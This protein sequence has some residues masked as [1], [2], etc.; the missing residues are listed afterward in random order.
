MPACS[1][2]LNSPRRPTH[3]PAL[4]TPSAPPSASAGT[5]RA[6]AGRRRQQQAQRCPV[7]GRAQPG[8]CGRPAG[9]RQRQGAAGC[10]CSHLGRRTVTRLPVWWWKYSCATVPALSRVRGMGVQWD[11]GVDRLSPQAGKPSATNTE[12]ACNPSIHPSPL[13]L[14]RH[15][16][17]VGGGG[18]AGQHQG[19]IKDVEACVGRGGADEVGGEQRQGRGE[20]VGFRGG[21]AGA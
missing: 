5:S 11:G 8:A 21:P 16:V 18:G 20:R 17:V 12:G 7:G 15:V 19:G 13:T 2:H 6:P 14:D 3:P 10:R 4:G 9:G 1:Q